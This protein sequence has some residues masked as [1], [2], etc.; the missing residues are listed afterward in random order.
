LPD[1]TLA[2]IFPAF[3]N[4]YLNHPGNLLPGF[5]DQFNSFIA[6]TENRLHPGLA[7]FDFETCNYLEDELKRQLVTYLYSC[8]ASAALR[9]S[10]MIP[11]FSAGYS[12]GLYAA[13]FDAGVISL[14]D[15][16]ILIRE[17]YTAIRELVKE[18]RYGMG[19]LIGLSRQD[20]IELLQEAGDTL[21][22][23]NQNAPFS[24]VISGDYSSVVRILELAREEGALHVRQLPVNTPYHCGFLES[25]A[26]QFKTCFP[27]IEF[28]P[29]LT[30]LHSLIDARELKDSLQ[31]REELTNNLF[32]PLNWFETMT[33]LVDSGVST[34]IECGPSRG[35]AKNAKFI[36]GK[37]RFLSMDAVQG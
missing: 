9:K 6:L 16:I 30:R 20:L 11:G 18:N 3:A 5:T 21:E 19:T 23:T 33:A 22:I 28:R 31:I 10:G 29:P 13:L 4:D 24:F 25:A 15:G 37:F 35:L 14:E 12:M 36:E 32:Q 8:A 17:A 27:E 34:L 26:K 7:D 1:P 2:F